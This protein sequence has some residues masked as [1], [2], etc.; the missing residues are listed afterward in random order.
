MKITLEIIDD[1]RVL[2]AFNA[3]RP[4]EIDEIEWI[5]QCLT[6]YISEK[7]FEYE[8]EKMVREFQ[9]DILDIK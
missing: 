7:T 3:T 8:R 6:K 1:K 2:A 9:P 4:E 5:K